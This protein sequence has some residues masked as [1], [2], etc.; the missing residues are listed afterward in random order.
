[1]TVISLVAVGVLAVQANGQ[2]PQTTS[3]ASSGQTGTSPTVAPSGSVNPTATVDPLAVP[4]NSGSG[5]R[6]VYSLAGR[7]V[8]LIGSGGKTVRL[9]FE[10][11]PG[12][13]PVPVGTYHVSSRD[14]GETGSDGLSVQYVVFFDNPATVDSSTSFAFDAEADVTGLPPAPTGQTG[15]V[16]MSQVDALAVWYFAPIGTPVIVV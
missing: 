1:M 2:S 3:A 13:I 11:V 16:R 9:T 14:S 5:E 4:A 6:V 10:I 15:A 8:W 12:T 7:R